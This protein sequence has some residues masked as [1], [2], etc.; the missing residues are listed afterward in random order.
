MSTALHILILLVAIA[1][2]LSCVYLGVL[3]LLSARLPTP[4]ASNQDMVFD[5]LIPAHNESQVIGRTLSNL[6]KLDWP[7]SNYRIL[8]IADNCTDDTAE[9]SRQA[10]AHVLERQDATRRGKGYALEHAF[11]Y[12][13]QGPATAVVVV[14]ADTEVTPNLLQACAARIEQGALAVQV[15]YGVLNPNDSWR[16]RL[17]TIAYGAFHAVR[18]RAR[19]RMGV[20]C[21]LRGNGAC[22]THELLRRHPFNIYSLTEDLEY[23]VLLGL[24]G[25]R[26]HYADEACADAEIIDSER[27]ARTQRSRWEGGRLAVARA[28]AGKLLGHAWRHRSA[29]SFELALDLLTLPLGNIVLQIVLLALVAGGAA[30]LVPAL[31]AWLWLP[32]ILLLILAAH[33]WRGWQLAPVGWRALADLAYVPFFILWKMYAKLRTRGNKGWVRTDRK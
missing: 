26:V 27:G 2:V 6:R 24:N 31:A 30:L 7:A 29:T 8:V 9:L 28:Y 10:G 21:G 3:T 20:S 15:N 19:E 22:Y 32:L 5:V 4:R 1:P 25:I 18:S 33:V 23:G 12:S 16:T 11:A 14:D 17:I 13:A